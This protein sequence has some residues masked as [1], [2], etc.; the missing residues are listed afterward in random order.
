[1][2]VNK[3]TPRSFS[4]LYMEGNIELAECLLRALCRPWAMKSEGQL[5]R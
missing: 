3:P 4:T 2:T 5:S 1:M